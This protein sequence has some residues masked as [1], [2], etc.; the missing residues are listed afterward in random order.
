M[1]DLMSI[2]WIH[3]YVHIRTQWVGHEPEEAKDDADDDDDDDHDGLSKKKGLNQ[4][5]VLLYN[6]TTKM[7]SLAMRYDRE[8]KSWQKKFYIM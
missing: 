3:K 1:V 2:L 6:A 8:R 4:Y 5:M 7:E